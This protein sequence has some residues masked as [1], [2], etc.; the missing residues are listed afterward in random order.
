M[1]AA[2]DVADPDRLAWIDAQTDHPEVVRARAK[3]LLLAERRFSFATGGAPRDSDEFDGPERVGG[4]RLVAQI[5]RGGMGAVY[6]GERDRGDFAHVAAIKIIKPGLL[7]DRLVE[8]FE[9]ERQT[10]AQLEHPNIARLYDGGE[11]EDGAPFIVME[12]ID[13]EP[14]LVWS[15]QH[16]LK[17]DARLALFEYVCGAVGFAHRSLVLH[18]DITP[19]N[20]LVTRDGTVKLIDFGIARPTLGGDGTDAPVS[21][22]PSLSLT[23]GF[24]APERVAGGETTTASDIYSLGKL[25]ARLVGA[26]APELDAIIERATHDDPLQRY[27]TAEALR[28]DVVALRTGMPVSAY[29][30]Q[31]RYV[32]RKFVARHRLAVMAAVAAFVL[33]TGAF[34][35]T[36]WAYFRS[37]RAVVAEAARFAEVRD[38]AGFMIFNLEKRLSRTA[39]TAEARVA[40]VERAQTYLAALER[41]RIADPDL[42]EEAARAYVELAFVR[43]VP[44]RP[45]LGDVE[46]SRKDIKAALAL[47]ARRDIP[48]AQALP[49]SALARAGLAMIAMHHD[50]AMPV[51]AAQLDRAQEELLRV[52]PADR[53][54]RWQVARSELRR[55]QLEQALLSGDVAKLQGTADLIESEA[56]A[57]SANPELALRGTI[58]RA[59]SMQYRGLAGY[60]EDAF[61]PAV[62]HFHKADALFRRAG[63]MR[64]GD[65][66]TLY[67][68]AYNGYNGHATSLGQP[69]H[70]AD[71]Y[72]FLKVARS[73]LDRLI[74]LEP[75]DSALRGFA[76]AVRQAYAQDLSKRGQHKAAIAEQEHVIADYRAA[77]GPERA[78]RPLN[79]L[80]VAYEALAIIA[81]EAGERGRA[82][83]ARGIAVERIDELTRRK[84]LLGSVKVMEPGIRSALRSCAAP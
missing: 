25:L 80:V 63:Q 49:T 32:F 4:Y 78:P 76:G 21:L 24:A 82:C 18:R 81:N 46:A 17:R 43:G 74:A 84:A 15:E 66:L 65:P 83:G 70:E 38:L 59:L 40:L 22:Q 8:R 79:K 2:A 27:P 57:S 23:P 69:G 36:A 68:M 26:G 42:A 71:S 31:K 67:L 37:E 19:S 56:D 52:Q 10:L 50:N 7:S 1:E 41:N 11:T 39:G 55:T 72:Y 3:S 47:T 64:P 58:D 73:T 77:L 13:G 54:V 44:G 48:A 51:A 75:R 12:L 6:R 9:R 20:V 60:F 34:A 62:A 33:L 29:S 30:G 53:S 14:I 45:N 16:Q 35:A 61:D 28:D 5:G